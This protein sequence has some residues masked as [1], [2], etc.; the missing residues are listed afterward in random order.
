M[1]VVDGVAFIKK[2]VSAMSRKDF[3][4]THL[5]FWETKPQKER[6]KILGEVY[7]MIV[8][9]KDSEKETE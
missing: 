7:D 1:I 6:E 3:I 8:P 2:N 5:C 4:K 9:K